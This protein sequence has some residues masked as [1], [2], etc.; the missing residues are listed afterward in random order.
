MGFSRG[1]R[2]SILNMDVEKAR[3]AGFTIATARGTLV[4]ALRSILPMV[5]RV[6]SLDGS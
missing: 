2:I 3:T 4:T 1:L 5:R 6:F